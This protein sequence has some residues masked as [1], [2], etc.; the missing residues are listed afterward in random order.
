MSIEIPKQ[1]LDTLEWGTHRAKQMGGQH[2]GTP[3]YG[4][5]LTSKEMGF[6]ISTDA[7]RSQIQAKE[8]CMTVFELFLQEIRAV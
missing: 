7:F 2:A 4:V 3:N 8:F 6:E 5:K 1:I